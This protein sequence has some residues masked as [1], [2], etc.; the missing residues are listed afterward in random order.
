MRLLHLYNNITTILR[1]YKNDYD[2]SSLLEYYI[3]KYSDLAS[4]EL[5]I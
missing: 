5:N 2:V 3:D 4:F 1:F